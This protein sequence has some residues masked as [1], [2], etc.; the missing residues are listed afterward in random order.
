MARTK[1][2]KGGVIPSKS[3]AKPKPDTRKAKSI[4]KGAPTKGSGSDTSPFS[5]ARGSL[6]KSK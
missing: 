4:S 3:V 5:S 2:P 6:G 1:S